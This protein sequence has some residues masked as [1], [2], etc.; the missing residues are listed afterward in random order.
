MKLTRREILYMIDELWDLLDS[1]YPA[2]DSSLI[3][4]YIYLLQTI[5]VDLKDGDTYDLPF[6]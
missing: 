1:R 6:R 2:A 5:A 3:L 4:Q